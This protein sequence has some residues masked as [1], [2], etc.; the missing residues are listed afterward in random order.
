MKSIWYPGVILLAGVAKSFSAVPVPE[1]VPTASSAVFRQ[2]CVS[3]HGKSAV[4][5]INLEQLLASPSIADNFAKWQKVAA[6][7]E[8][9]RMPPPKMPQPGDAERSAAAAGIRASLKDYA[10]KH[11]GD[12][13]GVTVRRL[14]S[15][16]YGYTVHDLT[17]LD[18][19]FDNEF[20]GDAVGGEGFAKFGDVQFI[21]D[22]NLERYMETAK[23]IAD[24]AVIG[25]GPV[26]F[27]ESA[28]KTGFELSA[29]HRIKDIY[30]TYGFRTVSGRGRLAF[31]SR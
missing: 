31:R 21:S 20:A 1:P 26:Q 10:L 9:K 17:G 19:N 16:E 22:A 15:A 30:A 24:H 4:A 25:S 5:G 28:G 18:L 27:F 3:C 7:L 11:D 6:V 14:T 29:V 2:Y 13:G 12:P 23:K 8:E